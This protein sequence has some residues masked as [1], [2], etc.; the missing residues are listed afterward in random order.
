MGEPRADRPHMPGYGVLPADQGTGLLPWAEAE[1]RLTASH[2]YWVATVYPDGRPHV[3]PVWGAWRDG[4]VWFSCSV[5]SRKTRNLLADPRCT[6]TTD[7][8]LD[9]VVVEG[10]AERT[11]QDLDAFIAEVNAK[12]DAQL[13]VDFLD[14]AVNTVWVVRPHRAFALNH[15]DFTG[16]PTRWAFATD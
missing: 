10:R 6:V 8:A 4:A 14:P 3:T 7:D 5:G 1:R 15:D 2:D 12:Y 13:T 9:P 16:S 11:T